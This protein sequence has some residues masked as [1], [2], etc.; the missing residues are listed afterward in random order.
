M[1]DICFRGNL[2]GLQIFIRQEETTVMMSITKILFKERVR[3]KLPS[4]EKKLLLRTKVAIY[5][6]FLKIR[7]LILDN[8][9]FKT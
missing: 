4:K 9:L 2:K 8:L 3:R 1:K 7:F 6:N 5:L